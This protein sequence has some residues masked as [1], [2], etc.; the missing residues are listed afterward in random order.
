MNGLSKLAKILLVFSVLC[1]IMGV[2]VEQA[3]PKTPGNLVMLYW[4]AQITLITS[5]LLAYTAIVVDRKAN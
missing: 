4:L 5:P 3:R 1:L 2:V